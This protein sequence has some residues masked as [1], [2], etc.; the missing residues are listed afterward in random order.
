MIL[1]RRSRHAIVALSLLAAC[2]PASA[3]N[4]TVVAV[5][6]AERGRRLASSKGCG[7]C[8][9]IPGVANADGTVGPPLAHWAQHSF[10]AGIEP[11]TAEQLQRWILHPQAVKPG[12]AMPELALTNSDAADIAAFL[13]SRR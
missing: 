5:G 11:N 12:V 8:H 6:D 3:G 13:F 1:F 2:R 9:T 4:G 10:I 7:A